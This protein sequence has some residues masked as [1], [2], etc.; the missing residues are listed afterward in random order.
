MGRKTSPYKN[1]PQWTTARF[2]TFLRSALRQAWSRYPPK[3]EAREAASVG[4]MRNKKTGR[5]AEHF[6]CADCHNVFTRK[7]THVDHIVD[8]GTLRCYE[9][10]QGFIERLF[11]S[12]YDLQVLCHDCHKTKTDSER[13]KKI[14]SLKPENDGANQGD[15]FSV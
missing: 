2:F 8:A 13:K 11:C 14:A 6:E 10:I 12:K 5:Q 9:D 15:L 1:Y 3:K 7:E 4:R